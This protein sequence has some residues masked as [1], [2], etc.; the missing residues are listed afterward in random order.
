M[1]YLSGAGL[2][3]LSWKKRPLSRCSVV[4]AI[5]SFL[6]QNTCERAFGVTRG[7]ILTSLVVQVKQVICCMC[8]CVCLDNNMGRLR[9]QDETKSSATAVKEEYL[10]SAFLAMVVH[11]KCS[12]MDHTV[13]PANNTMPAFPS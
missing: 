2:P 1:V 9:A 4:V 6:P 12:G 7:W 8:L 11:S 10:Y 3:R 13:L 5:K